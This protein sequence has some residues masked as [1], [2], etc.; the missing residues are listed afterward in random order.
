M[1]TISFNPDSGQPIYVQIYEYIKA[2]ILSGR[3]SRQEKLPSSR[4]LASHLQVSRST[5]DA[6]YSQLVSEGYVEAKEKRG[7]FVNPLTHTQNFPVSQPEEANHHS[8]EKQTLPLSCDFNPDAID[9][10]HFPYS[11]W[12][13]IGKRQLDNP[14]NFQMGDPL[15]DRELRHAISDYLHGSRGV[16][17]SP[18]TIVVGAGLD[19]LLQM[20]CILFE[21]KPVIALEDP[22][23]PRA[24]QIFLSGGYRVLDIPLKK[25]CFDVERL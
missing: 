16:N 19:Y 24:R 21:R 23:Y 15:G 14:D 9:T 11:I 13:S 17:C 22:S 10:A 2:E 12:K 18:E 1:I 25:N 7:Y 8:R 6:A 20:L 4:S 5:V 3:L